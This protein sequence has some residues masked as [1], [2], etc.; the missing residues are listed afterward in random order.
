MKKLAVALTGAFTLLCT[1]AGVDAQT[2]TPA[3]TPSGFD[4]AGSAVAAAAVI[5]VFAFI[6]YAGYKVIK[7]YGLSSRG[8]SD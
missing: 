4:I 6:A 8:E 3:A 2:A 5:V 7:K 1:V